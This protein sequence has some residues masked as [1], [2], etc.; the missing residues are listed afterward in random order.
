MTKFHFRLASVLRLREM[1]LAVEEEK[2]QLM[3]AELAQKERSLAALWQERAA[4]VSFVQERKDVGHAELRA[5][6][7]FLLGTS[8]RAAHLRENIQRLQNTAA[9]QRQ[10]VTVAQ[11]N[12]R[13][14]VKLKDAKLSEWQAQYD[15]ELESVAQET[16]RAVQSVLSHKH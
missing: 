5:L 15:R 2:L 13:L 16:W 9:E 14:L 1:Q 3:L 6:S 4:A 12:E 10:R 11:R 8:A 7:A